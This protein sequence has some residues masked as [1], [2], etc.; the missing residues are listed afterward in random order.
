MNAIITGATKGIGRAITIKLAQNGYNVA[1]CARTEAD[2]DEFK[3]ELDQYKVTVLAIKSDMSDKSEVLNFLS[4]TKISFKNLDVLVNNA[5]IFLPGS[6]LDEAD[7]VFEYQ[8][9]VNLHSVY[10][11]SKHVGLMMRNQRYGHIFNIS[12]VAAKKP[13]QNAGSYS[14]TKA[15]MLCLNDALRSELAQYNVKVTAV[16]PG[17]TLTAS[18]EGT[19]IDPA[20]FVQPEDIAEIVLSTLKLSAGVNVDELT[21]RPLNF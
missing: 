18:W 14:V 13:G 7:E 9:Q 19:T 17:A 15:A 3:L 20:K 12:S 11:L 5:G 16:L 8:T 6:L 1:I 2:L 10:Y 21:I 4:Q